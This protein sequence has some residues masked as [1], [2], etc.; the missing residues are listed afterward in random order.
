MPDYKKMYFKLA[1]KTADAGEALEKMTE[2]KYELI[3]AQ[4][5]CEKIYVKSKK[6]KIIEIEKKTP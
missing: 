6:T 3:N 1:A 4:Q 5:E 2:L